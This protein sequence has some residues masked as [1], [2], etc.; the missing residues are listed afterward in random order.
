MSASLMVGWGWMG[1][2]AAGHSSAVTLLVKALPLPLPLLLVPG[3]MLWVCNAQVPCCLL[4]C[5]TL[6][7][8]L[9]GGLIDLVFANEDEAAALLEVVA[10]SSSTAAGEAT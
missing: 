6:M 7:E 10:P 5:S 4:L 9:R 2:Q 3:A 8:L 1:A